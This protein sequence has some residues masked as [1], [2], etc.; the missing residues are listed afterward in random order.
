MAIHSVELWLKGLAAAAIAGA[1]SGV[2]TGF[3]A[4]G[5]D[6]EHFNPD[7]QFELS[8]RTFGRSSASVFMRV[9]TRRGRLGG[10]Y[11]V[12]DRQNRPFQLSFNA[13]LKVDF[14]GSRVASDGGLILVR[15]L[16]ER[17]GLEQLISSWAVGRSKRKPWLTR[18]FPAAVGKGK[19]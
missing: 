18:S 10:A 1:A 9:W 2:I 17:L 8:L 15:E 7:F 5:I 19:P 12:G 16:V 3:A 11:P 14:Q 6:P 13:P 4:V